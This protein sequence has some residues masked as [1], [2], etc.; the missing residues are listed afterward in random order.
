MR[1]RISGTFTLV[2]AI[3]FAVGFFLYSDVKLPW[4]TDVVGEAIWQWGLVIL[5]LAVL[6]TDRKMIYFLV[7]MW[8]CTL[9]LLAIGFVFTGS[10]SALV[11]YRKLVE[12]PDEDHMTMMV[13]RCLAKVGMGLAC[14]SC[15]LALVVSSLVRYPRDLLEHFWKILF[16]FAASLVVLDTTT[17]VVCLIFQPSYKD[18]HRDPDAWFV[19]LAWTP[20][21]VL[22]MIVL[23]L[24]SF[25]HRAQAVVAN[26]SGRVRIAAAI[27][28]LLSSSQDTE[29]LRTALSLFRGVSCENLTKQI[30]AN[31]TPD[32]SLLRLS[33]SVHLG[34]VDAFLSH[35]WHDD[36]DAKWQALQ[37]WRERFK[38]EH[39]GREPVIWIDKVCLDQ[40]NI[41]ES[42]R[43]LPIFLSGCNQLLVLAGE[44][45]L[46]RLWCIV[47]LFVFLACGGQFQ[48]L[49]IVPLRGYE[50]DEGVLDFKADKVTCSRPDD[51]D[52][53]LAFVDAGFGDWD[54]FSEQV[55]D[56][57]Q[58]A[59]HPQKNRRFAETV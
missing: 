5:S 32:G 11:L 10:R 29:T 28:T 17:F 7:V 12:N 38:L 37:M 58:K 33:K 8:C 43:C 26:G 34:E 31:N 22:T 25:R 14:T 59:S 42:L 53:L 19:S 23:S 45:Y 56:V 46:T 18:S 48:H 2:G 40:S 49:T 57:F 47:E 13:I 27:S 20:N 51:K 35:S 1:L 41:D 4:W 15:S 24:K 55:Q 9:I 3:L 30:M 16:V 54:N 39:N 44:T 36:A 21:E 50:L 6:P 52:R